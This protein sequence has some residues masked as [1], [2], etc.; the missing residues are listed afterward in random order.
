MLCQAGSDGGQPGHRL[1]PARGVEEVVSLPA[2]RCPRGGQ[3]LFGREAGE[4][5]AA[6]DEAD[7]G[8]AELEAVADGRRTVG[9]HREGG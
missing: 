8:E 3:G 1:V 5:P 4:V 6:A 9:R 2:N 7:V